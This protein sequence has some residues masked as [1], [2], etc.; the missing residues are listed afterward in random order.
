MDPAE[1]IVEAALAEHAGMVKQMRG[2]P[3]VVPERLAEGMAPRHCALSLVRPRPGPP[4]RPLASSNRPAW[5][6][7]ARPLSTNP[8]PPG[9]PGG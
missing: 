2:V 4:A 8:P 3:G 1:K 7:S 6:L 5:R 9:C